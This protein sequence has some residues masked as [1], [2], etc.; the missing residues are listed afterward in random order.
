MSPNPSAACPTPARRGER[1]FTLI[2]MTVSI[3][4]MVQIVLASLMV[5]DFN[6]KLSRA[7]SQITDMQQSLRVAQSE[8]VRLARMAGRGGLHSIVPSR[9][10]PLGAAIEVRNNAGGATSSQLAVGYVNT[11]TVVAG[12]DVLIVR[13]VFSGQI[14]QLD[15]KP[16]TYTLYDAANNLTTDP[17]V[18]V[19][20]VVQVCNVSPA[21]LPA[22]TALPIQQDLSPL[23]FAIAN[24]IPEALVLVSSSDPN[25]YAVVKL[26]AAASQALPAS[27]TCTSLGGGTQAAFTVLGDTWSNAYQRLGTVT[28]NNASPPVPTQNMPRALG[29]AAYMGVVEEYRYYVRQEYTIA[30]NAASEPSPRLSRAR[31]YPGTELPY[32]GDPA[33]LSVDVADNI[34]DLQLALGVDVN[35]DGAVF[36]AGTAAD[37]WLYNNAADDPAAAGWRNIV[38]NPPTIPATAAPSPP[39]F[40]VRISTLARTGRRDTGYQA[41][42][43]T[44]IEDHAYNQNPPASSTTEANTY[45]NRMFRRRV[46]QTVVGL[47]NL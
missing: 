14:W 39:M 40:Y 6:Q 24:N 33:N 30:G 32:Q 11:P 31:L 29:Q 4:I 38:T 27:T 34:L 47:R 41:P 5:L 8:M 35:N 22:P 37:E 13:G 26:D 16:A 36:D 46:L 23:A 9:P 28:A 43:V 25:A 2:E 20:G 3:I 12:T 45:A 42:L 15:T 18:A 21:P 10:T 19:R 1:G 44:Q 17:T 7:Q